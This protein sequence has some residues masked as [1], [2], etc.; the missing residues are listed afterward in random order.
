MNGSYTLS[1]FARGWATIMTPMGVLAWAISKSVLV[2]VMSFVA[3]P[4]I[5][6]CQGTFLILSFRYSFSDSPLPKTPAHGIVVVNPQDATQTE[7]L[8]KDCNCQCTAGRR[9]RR[10]AVSEDEK[11]FLDRALQEEPLRI[12]VIGDSLALGIGVTSS[13]TAILPEVIAKT[14]SKALRRPV[15][16]TSHGVP[17]ASSGWIV[18]EL[19]RGMSN[20][21]RA[22]HIKSKYEH[23]DE[24]DDS[25]DDL[26]TDGMSANARVDEECSILKQWRNRLED[27]RATDLDGPFDVVIVLTGA[28]DVKATLF[29]FLMGREESRFLDAAQ[30]RGSSW[31]IELERILKCVRPRM[32]SV[33]GPLVVFP[34]LPSSLLP[35]FRDVPVRWHAVP[36]LGVMENFKKSLAET[37]EDCVFVEAPSLDL[38]ICFE[39]Q[40]GK[41]WDQRIREDTLLALRDVSPQECA[42]ITGTLRDYCKRKGYMPLYKNEVKCQANIP[43]PPLCKRFGHA[44]GSKLVFIDKV[45]ANDEGFDFW[46][47]YIADGILRQWPSIVTSV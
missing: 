22:P 17:G 5:G 7:E 3:V 10:G 34:A 11:K 27:I 42:Y 18:Q 25:S 30:K 39:S 26:S 37:H 1:S 9:W 35:I 13:C 6:F 28:N 40:E 41:Y 33:A 14:L 24:T 31:T 36:I 20:R 2:S 44:D 32:S 45:H 47:R 12:L 16:W 15:Y 46:G 19:Q 38:S 43:D 29:P 8:G 23:G 4:L 21:Y